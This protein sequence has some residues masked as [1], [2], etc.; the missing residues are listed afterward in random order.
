M[1]KVKTILIFLS[2]AFISHA[3]DIILKRTGDEIKAKV[4]E[5]G[6][7]DIKYHRADNPDGPIYIVPKSDVFKITYKDGSSDVFKNTKAN[8]LHEQPVVNAVAATAANT[9]AIAGNTQHS[10]PLYESKPDEYRRSSLYSILI[11]HPE[12]EFCNEIVTAF[13]AIPLPDKYDDHNLKIRVVNAYIPQK[14]DKKIAEQQREN[15]DKF[16]VQ[17]DIGRRLIAKWFNRE[18]ETGCFDMNLVAAR[19]YYNASVLD[20]KLAD[21]SVR[22]KAALADAGEELIGNTFVIVNDIR[23]VDKEEQADVAAGIFGVISIAGALTGT[24]IGNAVSSIASAGATISDQIAGFKVNVTSYLYRLNWTDE[25]AGT[26]YNNYYMD[27]FNVDNNRKMAFDADRRTFSITYVGSQTVSSGK[28][29]LGGVSTKEDMIKK[30]CTRAIDES[31]V[32]LQKNF[33][34]FKV[35]SPLLGVSP[36]TASIGKKEGVSENS[37]FEVLERMEDENGKT[38]YKRVGTIKP[39]RGKIWDNRYL[40]AAD[41]FAGADLGVTEFK[42]VSGGNFAP[43]MLIREIK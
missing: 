29:T 30:V 38:S 3:Q 9:T 14:S 36:I 19:G 20:V 13:N 16:I 1:Q 11:K 32:Q 40:S 34:E 25:I 31:I 26:F 21:M 42:K 27:K 17:N 4:V 33:D 22:G 39:V 24:N 8:S 41:G 2:V 6:L 7:D 23:Y 5:V 43:G 18:K 35:K 10:K 15:I 12:K 28:T 37:R